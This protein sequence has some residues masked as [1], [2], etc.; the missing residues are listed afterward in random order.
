M[1][2]TTEIA[3]LIGGGCGA[4]GYLLDKRK[5]AVRTFEGLGRVKIRNRSEAQMD[6]FFPGQ[7]LLGITEEGRLI[8]IDVAKNG[9]LVP[10]LKPSGKARPSPPPTSIIGRS[11]K[12]VDRGPSHRLI[13][14]PQFSDSRGSLSF[15]E[16]GRHL[17]FKIREV[18][19]IRGG[20]VP[21]GRS[22]HPYRGRHEFIV[23]LSGSLKVG[24]RDDRE[25]QSYLLHRPDQ[26]LHVS[27]QAWRQL[28]SISAGTT[29]LVLASQAQQ[30]RYGRSE[31]LFQE[32]VLP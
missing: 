3:Q 29:A 15:I 4:G 1:K 5:W 25:E 9:R 10:R 32:E 19:W 30:E 12:S 22:E 27:D 8:G 26:G 14:L 6:G 28:Q 20:M 31:S 7:M 18:V 16:S 21:A 2:H 11:R 23:V 24:V 17:P 13:Q